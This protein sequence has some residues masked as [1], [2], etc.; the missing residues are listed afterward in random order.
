MNRSL[1]GIS[2]L[3]VE[4]EI[5]IGLMLAKEL[6]RA[7]SKPIGPV[8]SVVD[9]FKQ[10]ECGGVDAVVLDAKLVDGSGAALAACLK[11][12]RIPFVVV[13]GYEKENLPEELRDAPFVAKPVSL[14]AL[15]DAIKSLC[16]SSQVTDA[17]SRVYNCP[18]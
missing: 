12:R 11:E 1:D 8:T 15:V 2:I 4:D 5:I 7:G 9:A 17:S 6:G 3:I 18:L 13:S 16:A 10:I 14:P